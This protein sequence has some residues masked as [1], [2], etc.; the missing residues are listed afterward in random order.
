MHEYSL[1]Q[2]L[3][4]RVERE[5][6]ARDATGVHRVMVRIGSMGG[7]EPA[8]FATA[9]ELGRIGT[10]CERAELVLKTEDVRW[11]CH[12]C[13]FD[14]PQ[15]NALVCPRCGWPARMVGGDAL[16]LEGLELE[17]PAHV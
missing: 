4:D 6:R 16:L 12:A 2:A 15:G 3:L 17:V 7:V 5:A 9:F 11:E 14:I 1:V 8:L 13:G 10:I